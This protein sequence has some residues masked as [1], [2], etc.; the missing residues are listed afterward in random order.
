MIAKVTQGR[1][2]LAVH[3][4]TLRPDLT[5]SS[6]SLTDDGFLVAPVRDAGTNVVR[7][8]AT[9]FPMDP[10]NDQLIWVNS[11][12]RHGGYSQSQPRERQFP[13][14]GGLTS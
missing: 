8:G 14:C 13:L 9:C 7:A 6:A 3:T 1:F 5:I 2:H 4:S 10:D 11:T 12:Q